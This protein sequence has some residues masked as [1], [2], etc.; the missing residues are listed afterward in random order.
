MEHGIPVVLV[1]PQRDI[2][3]PIEEFLADQHRATQPCAVRT[4]HFHVVDASTHADTCDIEGANLPAH[5][6]TYGP[7][8]DLLKAQGRGQAEVDGTTLGTGVE[9]CLDAHRP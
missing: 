8:S 5:C 1:P 6:V 4:G 2:L 9:F 7:L 3:D